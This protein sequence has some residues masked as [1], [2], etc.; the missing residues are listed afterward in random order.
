MLLRQPVLRGIADGRVS[1]AFRRWD[2]PR[3]KVGTRLRTS[4]GT[5]EVDG[6]EL[7]EVEDITEAEAQLAG[8]PRDELLRFLAARPTRPTYRITLHLA[9]P[10]PRIA[11]RDDAAPS[12]DELAVIDATLQ[13][14]DRASRHGAWTAVTLDTI[15]ARPA[16]RA[17]DLAAA[18]GR[19]TQPFKIDVRKL[20]ELGL[21]E[22]LE[23]GY[24]LS[25]RGTAYQRHRRGSGVG[26]S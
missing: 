16:T 14:L 24:R 5:L 22:S 17:A 1:L 10:D 3:V 8:M 11:L 12:A 26:E 7:V 19:D 15:E 6:V 4:V 21:T 18:L 9:G 25:P 13:R 23:V 2:R 20:K